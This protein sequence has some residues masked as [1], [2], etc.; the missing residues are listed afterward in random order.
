MDNV[1]K[2]LFIFFPLLNE[3]LQILLNHFKQRH[4][5]AVQQRLNLKIAAEL[6]VQGN[7]HHLLADLFGIV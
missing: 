3:M 5:G 4:D 2:E 7:L 6:A 1:L